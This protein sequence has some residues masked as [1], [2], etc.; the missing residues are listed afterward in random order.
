[1]GI[2]VRL[3]LMMARVIKCQKLIKLLSTMVRAALEYEVFL[4]QRMNQTQEAKHL[5]STKRT[6]AVPRSIK[7]SA[8]AVSQSKND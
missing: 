6:P 4:L 5:V 1:M 3:S 7:I 2:V 8:P